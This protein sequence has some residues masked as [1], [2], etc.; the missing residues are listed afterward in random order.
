LQHTQTKS[1]TI[2]LVNVWLN[3]NIIITLKK[4]QKQYNDMRS[5]QCYIQV[6]S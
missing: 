3:A 6:S 1:N 4:F 2:L 5:N